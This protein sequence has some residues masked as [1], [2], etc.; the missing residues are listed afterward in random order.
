M[1]FLKY[2]LASV[3]FSAA[4]LVSGEN[5]WY[6]ID[7]EEKSEQISCPEDDPSIW[8]LFSKDLGGKKFQVRFPEDPIYRYTEEGDL[9][10]TS[11]KNKE[12]FQLT[13]KK[14]ESLSPQTLTAEGQWTY[15]HFVETESHQFHLKAQTPSLEKANQFFSSL[16]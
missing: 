3:L 6:P 5:G 13:V 16:C 1:I 12:I 2:L 4:P 9:E 8:V 15:E 7:K 11:Q 10:I 14:L